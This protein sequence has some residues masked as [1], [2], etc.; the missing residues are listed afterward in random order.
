M[1]PTHKRISRTELKNELTAKNFVR[2]TNFGSNEIYD[3]HGDEAPALMKEV[4]RLREIA[5]REAGGGTGLDIDIDDFDFGA[6]AYRQLIVWD[7]KEKEIVGGYRYKKLSEIQPDE[8]GHYNLATSHMFNFS[9]KFLTKY[10]PKT[11]EL[12]RS[13]VQPQYQPTKD[14]RKGLFSLD[15]LWDGLGALVIL[16]PDFRYFFGKM[17]M[18]LK[19][20]QVARD[21][22]LHF[23]NKYF[24]D[25]DALVIPF[26]EKKITTDRSL[27]RQ[28]TL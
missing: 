22:I 27:Y 10:F 6:N 25:P 1:Q 4:G 23:L 8:K 5:F 16:H 24:P 21:M 17:T 19:Y 13:F 26:H 7:P 28:K 3:F 18:Y 14:S 11:I 2:N 20:N 9:E 12:G 15:N